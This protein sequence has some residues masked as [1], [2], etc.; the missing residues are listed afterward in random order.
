VKNLDR[1]SSLFWLILSVAVCIRSQGL[2]LGGLHNPGPGFLFFWCGIVLGFLSVIIFARTL[3][4]TEKGPAEGQEATFGNVNWRKVLSVVMAL[5]VYG[6][7]L[8]RLG[9]VLSTSCFMAF[10]LQSIEAKRWTVVIFVSVF[11]ALLTYALFELWLHA[12]LPRG[13]VGL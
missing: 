10:L 1:F 4:R 8:E 6:L 7:I 11:S 2:G 12:R 9:F 3:V 13:I 5:V